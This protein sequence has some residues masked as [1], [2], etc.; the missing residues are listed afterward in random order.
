MLRTGRLHVKQGKPV[1]RHQTQAKSAHPARAQSAR[2]TAH[3][4]GEQRAGDRVFKVAADLFYTQSIRAVGVETIVKQAGVAKISLYRSFESKDDLIVAYL[5]DRN[6]G[7]WRNIDRI[8]AT[9]QQDPRAQLRALVS[10]VAG[11][12]TTP[13]YRGCPFINYASEFPDPS[14]PGHRIVEE[15]KREMRRRLVTLSQAVGASR[16]AQL[17]DALFLLIEGAYASSQ[18]LGGHNGPAAN[19]PRATDTLIASHLNK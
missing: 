5:K 19:L 2:A 13:G 7:Y 8:M 10:H 6:V 11:R 1:R 12:A 9:K 15:N 18:T 14:H 16:P 3:V 17:A 4:K